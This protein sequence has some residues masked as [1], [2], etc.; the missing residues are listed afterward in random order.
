MNQNEI[1]G[2][3]ENE[4]IAI[5]KDT[6]VN[7]LFP[8]FLKLEELSVLIVGGG[9]VGHEKLSAILQNSPLTN[10]KLVSISISDEVRSLADSTNVEVFERAFFTSDLDLVDIVII[11]I[12]DHDMSSRIRDEAKSRGKLVNVADKPELCDFYLSSVVQKGDLKLAISTNG[13]S[14]TT[15]KRLKEVLQEAL[16]DELNSVIDNL[17]KIRN[18][19][20]W[21]F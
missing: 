2:R 10:I 18:E 14:P 8:I 21:Q 5:E 3:P 16:P 12:D 19:A 13:K 6:G 17:H 20:E 7:N 11:A 4:N 9:K 15:A 1:L